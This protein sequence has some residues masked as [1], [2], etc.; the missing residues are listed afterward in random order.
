MNYSLVHEC[1]LTS[2]TPTSLQFCNSRKWS[3]NGQSA[4][5]RGPSNAYTGY[6]FKKKKKN[7]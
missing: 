5:L 2:Q 4:T 3:I 1:T 6:I 7:V